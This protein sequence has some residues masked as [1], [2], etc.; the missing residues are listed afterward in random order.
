MVN[1]YG[2]AGFGLTNLQGTVTSYSPNLIVERFG[3][4]SGNGINGY[5]LDGVGTLGLG[6]AFKLN[7][8]LNLTIENSLKI[9]DANKF[10]ENKGII[11]FDTYSYSS[12]GLSYNFGL[13][14]AAVVP[15]KK[16]VLTQT[17]PVEV[18]KE[19][20]PVPAP[21]KTEPE[22]KKEVVVPAPVKTE[23][24]ITPPEPAK[25]E[26]K[27]VEK[28]VLF[29]G[30]KVQI[31]A[32][33]SQASFEKIAVEFNLKEQIRED[34][35]DKWYRYSVGEFKSFRE[36]ISYRKILYSRNKIK[37]AFLVKFVDGKR[38]GPVWK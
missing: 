20:A 24:K 2:L 19:P 22:V 13:K 16:E 11:H 8:S 9:I 21:V 27:P 38:I 14:K 36:A 5:E 6:I 1:I 15:V 23:Q 28:T 25:Q 17:K 31:A 33:L 10:K 30:Y 29:T 12:I 3:Y 37:G 35:F 26:V 34:H 32:T 4:G 7:K 18:K